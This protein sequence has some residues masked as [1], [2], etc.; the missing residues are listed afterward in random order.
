MIHWILSR[1]LVHICTDFQTSC[2]FIFFNSNIRG[3]GKLVR[4]LQSLSL[5][6]PLFIGDMRITGKPVTPFLLATV[7]TF[8]HPPRYEACTWN[9]YLFPR[10][11]SWMDMRFTCQASS[12]QFLAEHRFDFNKFIYTVPPTR[13]FFPLKCAVLTQF[14]GSGVSF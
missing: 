10:P 2:K 5:V 4:L 13:L 11:Y 8:A 7:Q 3:L 12:L 6:Y 14:S 1:R 9:I